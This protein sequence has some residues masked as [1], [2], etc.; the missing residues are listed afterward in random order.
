LISRFETKNAHVQAKFIEWIKQECE[1]GDFIPPLLVQLAFVYPLS[2]WQAFRTLQRSDLT[3][4]NGVAI[5]DDDSGTL[6]RWHV[7]LTPNVLKL[8]LEAFQS[9]ARRCGIN[10]E[11][12]YHLHNTL[13]GFLKSRR[14]RFRLLKQLKWRTL[15]HVGT[16][17][18]YWAVVVADVGLMS[19]ILML[20]GF[21]AVA[22]SFENSIE[23]IAPVF[24]SACAA[25]VCAA[26]GAYWRLWYQIHTAS[27]ESMKEFE[28]GFLCFFRYPDSEPIRG[29][30]CELPR[31]IAVMLHLAR[32]ASE[33][34]SNVWAD[35]ALNLGA[36]VG[37]SA[38]TGTLFEVASE[39]AKLRSWVVGE[40]EQLLLKAQIV[41]ASGDVDAPKKLLCPE[42][43]N[44]EQV[45]RDVAAVSLV[46]GRSLVTLLMRAAGIRCRWWWLRTVWLIA[47]PLFLFGC[48]D[49]FRYFIWPPAKPV[50]GTCGLGP[51]RPPE[52]ESSQDQLAVNVSNFRGCFRLRYADS[53][54]WMVTDPIATP[55]PTNA[56]Y[57]RQVFVLKKR[58]DA[59]FDPYDGELQIILV[60]RMLWIEFPK[61]INRD[62]LRAL[63]KHN[64]PYT[65]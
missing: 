47:I 29:R 31:A 2:D 62:P 16:R 34:R 38:A 28:R 11:E 36:D 5:R 12:I 50:Y 58:V 61:V 17:R 19:L 23:A 64:T 6:I 15:S 39:Q 32:Q 48:F 30:S 1:T 14:V 21:E 42:Q 43:R 63:L 9:A 65:K 59:G 27:L 55:E 53:G 44:A 45:Q 33:K 10:P 18:W 54:Y 46:K 56:A 22:R 24:I 26:L 35:I 37:R 57:Q 3:S 60:R 25:L 7:Y 8:S 41:N 4:A 49:A 40:V 51:V 13:R 20:I 52:L